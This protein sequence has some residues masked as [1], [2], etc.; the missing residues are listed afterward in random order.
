MV[1]YCV[2]ILDFLLRFGFMY[3]ILIEPALIQM[4]TEWN[5]WCGIEKNGETE[6]EK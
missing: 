2:H 3:T 4:Q 1:E 6:E 5:K